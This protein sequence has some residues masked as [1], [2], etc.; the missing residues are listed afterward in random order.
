MIK[1]KHQIIIVGAGIAGLSAALEAAQ[2]GNDVAVVSKVTPLHSHSVAAQ[3]GTAAALGNMEPDSWEWH[4]YDTVKGS[5][6]LG[7]QDAQAL[8]CKEAI[9][10]AYFLEHIG[11]PFSRGE[12]G[13][14]L[15]RHFGGHYS[16]FGKGPYIKRSCLAA[17]RIG[18]AILYTLWGQCLRLQVKFYKEFLV[19]HILLQDEGC[20][21]VIAWDIVRGEMHIFQ[22]KLTLLATGGCA[23]LFKISTNSSI[24]TGDGMGMVLAAGLPLEDM[25]FI[26]FHPTG[27]YPWGFLISEGVRGEGGYLLNQ[28]GERFMKIYAPAKLELAPRDVVS[29]A[30]QGE[31][32]AGR[33]IRGKPYVYLDITHLEDQL[34]KEKLPQIR[35][36]VLKFAGIDPKKQPIPVAPT[37]HYTMGGI[38]IN[39]NCEV[40]AD[41]KK[42]IVP[43]LFAAGECACVSIHGAN[44]LGTNSTMECA[45]FGR[46]AGKYM[47]KIAKKVNFLPLPQGQIKERLGE[48]NTLLNRT[49]KTSLAEVREALEEGMTKNC[50]IL[51]D[52]SSL[53]NQLELIH[54]LKTAYQKIGL[55]GMPKEYN[56]A[57]QEVLELKHMLNLSEAI[58]RCALARKESR[59]AHYRNDFPHRD[60]KNWLKHT[61]V[62][63]EDEKYKLDYKPV[64]ITRF[65][66]EER[67][68]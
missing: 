49:P 51:R 62:F 33:G 21:G 15:Q 2:A 20:S 5:D 26:Q 13:R 52:E 56:L 61:L 44:R 67:Q 4:F 36:M 55:K 14:I 10:T 43:R 30:I 19:T 63:I 37:A 6:F 3:G 39:I 47:A 29:R 18:Q 40:L 31:I 16:E 12:N 41:G 23:R 22:G 54:Q 38:P 50:G 64:V 48:I 53:K 45:V 35:Q 34:I 17:D 7:D 59:G 27:L 11:V 24:N 8:F 58:V 1:H 57:L 28:D 60:D 46:R 66:P 32:R 65:E 42:T 9:E 68:F 25:E